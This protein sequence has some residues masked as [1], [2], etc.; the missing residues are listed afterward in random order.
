VKYFIGFFFFLTSLT[1]WSQ[2]ATLKGIVVN[3]SGEGIPGV[4]LIQKDNLKNG[5]VTDA[6]GKF[7]LFIP[8]E[9]DITVSVKGIGSEPKETIFNLRSGEIKEVEIMYDGTVMNKGLEVV[10]KRNQE[11]QIITISTKLPTKLPT[12][13]Q[14]IEA[15]L[16]QAPVNF[17]SEL[18]SSF[19]VRGGSFDENLIYDNDFSSQ[20]W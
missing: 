2:N 18:S 13:N 15:Y 7:T 1:N 19:N 17:P 6:Y 9:L 16:I 12:I 14:G 10:D 8:A 5:T 3:T 11:N 4:T 20:I